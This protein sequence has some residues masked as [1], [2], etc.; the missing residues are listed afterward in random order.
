M[1]KRLETENLAREAEKQSKLALEASA[2][3]AH[4]A[5]LAAAQS[6]QQGELADLAAT[7]RAELEKLATAASSDNPDI[8]LAM[9]FWTVP[10]SCAFLYQVQADSA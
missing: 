4:K 3:A 2:T 1:A 10:Q 6:K 8:L 9:I 5:A 7:R